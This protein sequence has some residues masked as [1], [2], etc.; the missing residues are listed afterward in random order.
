MRTWESYT[1]SGD[2]L[3]KDIDLQRSLS[4]IN[5]DTGK[6]ANQGNKMRTYR[7]LKTI[8]NNNNNNNNNNTI[9]IAQINW[10]TGGYDQMRFTY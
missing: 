7:L 9:Y 8:D 10:H 4:E 2:D 5:N 3:I 6:D 1:W